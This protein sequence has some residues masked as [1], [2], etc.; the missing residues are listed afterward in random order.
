[1]KLCL[2]I[3]TGIVFS[4]SAMIGIAGTDTG[5]KLIGVWADTKVEGKSIEFAK[6]G[7]VKLTEK[8]GEKTVTVSGTYALKEG[9]LVISFVPPGKEKAET[10]TGK[11]KK[12]TDKELV[13]E[14]R[15]GKS[16]EYK[17]VK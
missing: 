14:D 5:K 8:V 11:I 6:D 17:R 15:G 16:L 13:I 7:K 1:M 12:L 10:D 3:V 4:A 2:V 9:L